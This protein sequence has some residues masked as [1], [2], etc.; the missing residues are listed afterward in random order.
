MAL[1]PKISPMTASTDASKRSAIFT[2]PP[3]EQL[4]APL[5]DLDQLDRLPAGAF[6]HHG[7]GVAEPI[8]LLQDFNPFCAQLGAPGIE[9][10]DAE[11]DMVV[12]LSARARER[13]VSLAHVPRQHDIAEQDGRGRRAESAFPCERGPAGI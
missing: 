12:Q 6:D 3:A 7:A 8:G 4:C 13:L 11:R 5:L 2:I 1:A 9:I 10:G